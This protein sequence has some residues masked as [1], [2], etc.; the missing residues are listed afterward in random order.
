MVVPGHEQVSVRRDRGFDDVIVVGIV[1]DE[2][3]AEGRLNGNAGGVGQQEL[4]DALAGLVVTKARELGPG[5]TEPH[6][7][8]RA[9]DTAKRCSVSTNCSRRPWAVEVV[10]VK[11]RGHQGAG[12][13][14]DDHRPAL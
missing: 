9:G 13:Q 14:D 5:K 3:E 4:H 11:Q 10:R 2:S 6:S 12:V 8:A 7:A 1:G